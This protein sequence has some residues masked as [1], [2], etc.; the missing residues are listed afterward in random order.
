[1]DDAEG[2]VS[3][4]DGTPG[5]SAAGGTPNG[6]PNTSWTTGEK[7]EFV[8]RLSV[9]Q[10]QAIVDGLSLNVVGNARQLKVAIRKV[11]GAT[12]VQKLRELS[13]VR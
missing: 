1:M 7:K 13:Q 6:T 3:V 5:N 12:P 9:L 10:L 4:A 8:D 11:L 2:K